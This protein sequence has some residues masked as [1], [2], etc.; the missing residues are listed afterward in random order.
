[1]AEA[2]LMFSGTTNGELATQ[3]FHQEKKTGRKIADLA[4]GRRRS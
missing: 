2:I 4:E 1:M 3:G